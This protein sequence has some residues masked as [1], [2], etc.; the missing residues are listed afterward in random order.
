[1]AAFGNFLA[2]EWDRQTALKRGGGKVDDEPRDLFAA[3]EAV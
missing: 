1:M 2:N 3:L